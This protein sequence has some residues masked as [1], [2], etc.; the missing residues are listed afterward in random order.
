MLN[1][2]SNIF[3]M[4]IAFSIKLIPLHF[5][6]ILLLLFSCLAQNF[7]FRVSQNFLTFIQIYYQ[8]IWNFLF[9]RFDYSRL[10]IIFQVTKDINF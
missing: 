9:E 5:I 7:N 4:I 1:L 6:Q 8:E 10:D 3:E 2:L